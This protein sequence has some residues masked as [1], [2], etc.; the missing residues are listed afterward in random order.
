[1]STTRSRRIPKYCHYKPKDLAVVRI[2]GKDYYLGKHNS[3]ESQ[4]KYAQLIAEHFRAGGI[5]APLTHLNGGDLTINELVARY[6]TEY[7]RTYHTKEG[8]PTDSTTSAWRYAH[9]AT[10]TAA[11]APAS[12]DPE[13]SKLY[14]RR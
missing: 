5:A 8:K 4:E 9:S 14:G 3:P 12:S 2:N 10:F 6:W 7:V 13:S 11:S 1:M